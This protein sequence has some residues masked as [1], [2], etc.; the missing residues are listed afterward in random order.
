MFS[1]YATMGTVLRSAFAGNGHTRA[2]SNGLVVLGP[3]ELGG[4]ADLA[5]LQGQEDI[6]SLLVHTGL[7]LL[8]A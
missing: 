1:Y 6:S 2:L 5:S 7:N 3:D 4:F 8:G